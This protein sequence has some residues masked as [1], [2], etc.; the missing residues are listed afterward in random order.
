MS[1]EEATVVTTLATVLHS[2]SLIDTSAG[3]SVA[4]MGCGFTGL[5]HIQVV[6][7]RGAKPIIAL[8]RSLWKLDLAEKLG[9]DVKVRSGDENVVSR[10]RELTENRGVDLAI[11]TVGSAATLRECVELVR[12]GGK[13]LAFGISSDKAGELS[14]F[15]FYYKQLSIIGS[16]AMLPGD[17]IPSIQMITASRC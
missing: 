14:L 9:A 17:W 6:K 3:G 4:I 15:P 10:V 13:V 16:R 2:H 1:F 8:T 7:L 11:E 5:L 12:L